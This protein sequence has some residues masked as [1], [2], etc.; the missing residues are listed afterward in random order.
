MK[1]LL[2]TL[3]VIFGLSGCNKKDEQATANVE[4]QPKKELLFY[5]GITMVKPITEIAKIVEK[6]H[7]C[8]IRITQGGS[9]DLYASLS[10]SKIGDLYLPGSEGYRNKNLKD[11]FLKDGVYVGYNQ[12]GLIVQKGNPKGIK[13]DLKELTNDKYNVVLCNP[14]SGSIGKHTKSILK[15]LD[16]QLY[17]DA[18]SNTMSLGTDS[19][20]LNNS[21]KNKDADLT[22]NW[23]ATAYWAGNKE[24]MDVIRLDSKVAPKKKLIINLLSFS[25]HPDIAKDFMNIASSKVGK[26]IFLKYGF[27]D[28]EELTSEPK[29]YK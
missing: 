7:N 15:K 23:L 16:R 6:K 18:Y 5:C 27:L 9:K 10:S 29:W 1:H 11:G 13:A 28:K 24:Y 22:V 12:A 25:K 17:Q 26:D 19:R 8:K 20:T 3:L 4:E 2:I 14:D 21:I